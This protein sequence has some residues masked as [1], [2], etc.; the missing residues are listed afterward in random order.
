MEKV[1]GPYLTLINKCISFARN[2]MELPEQIEFYF[3]ECP[4][5]IF[6]TTDNAA[7]SNENHI[8]FNKPWFTGADRWNNHPD[9]IEF[10]VFHEL[11]HLYQLHEIKRLDNGLP[12]HERKSTVETWKDGFL[13]YQR[14]EGGASQA[15]NISQ[16]VEIDA[17]AYALCLSNFVHLYD[18]CELHLSLPSEAMDLVDARSKTYYET[19]PEFIKFMNEER[20]RRNVK[21]VQRRIEHKPGR[22]DPCPCGSGKK[23]KR[24][25]IG[26]G[27]YD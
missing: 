24:C 7:E 2:F 21:S 14:N 26:K 27:M 12:L 3:E 8:V 9:D 13:N 17:N 15:I 16:E 18:G 1:Q 4:S 20:M 25:C 22:N 6:P 10:F 23:F 19:L 5:A 11:R